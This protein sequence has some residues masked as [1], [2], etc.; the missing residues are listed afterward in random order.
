MNV[1][2]V[3]RGIF[4][5]SLKAWLIGTYGAGE[6]DQVIIY[7]NISGWIFSGLIMAGYFFVNYKILQFTGQ[8]KK[9]EQQPTSEKI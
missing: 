8:L 2:F 6:Y 7:M 9:K 4:Q 3:F 1:L 5:N